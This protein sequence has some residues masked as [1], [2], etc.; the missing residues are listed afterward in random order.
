MIRSCSSCEGGGGSSGSCDFAGA[1]SGRPV[2]AYQ[3]V[4][5]TYRARRPDGAWVPGS[6]KLLD[7]QAKLSARGKAA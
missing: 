2:Q 7:M 4:Y 3:N 5:V 1:V 6:L